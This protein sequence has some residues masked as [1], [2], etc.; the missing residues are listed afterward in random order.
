MDEPARRLIP[1]RS[2]SQRLCRLW[3][4]L[5]PALSLTLAS[6][7]ALEFSTARGDEHFD[8]FNTETPSWK[9]VIQSQADAKLR[10]HRRNLFT[11][12]E[13]AASENLE[14]D[15]LRPGSM[16]R[17]EHELPE[18]AAIDDLALDIGYRSN[19]PGALL[20]L[21][22]VFPGQKDPRT[23]KTLTAL[24]FGNTYTATGEWQNLRVNASKLAVRQR[25]ARL[26]SE[27]R[28]S[29]ISERN[30]FI[31]R[32]IL[33][34][35]LKPGTTELFIDDLKWTGYATPATHA[36]SIRQVSGV[37]S[38]D[39]APQRFEMRLDRLLID[40][41]PIMPRFTLHHGES[42][43]HLKDLGINLVWIDDYA[44]QE[45]LREIRGNEMW[46]MATPPQGRISDGPAADSIELSLNTFDRTS[47][48]ILF[49]YMGTR[50]PGTPRARE[51][52]T[53]QVR[54]VRGADRDFGRP[55]I[56]DIGGY[57][58][59]YSRLLDGVGLSRHPLQTEFSLHRYRQFLTQK[60]RQ[61]RPGTFVTTWIQTEFDP[62]LSAGL[63]TPPL[64][65]PEQIRLQTYAAIAAG[66]QGI[67]FW[68][69]TSLE[70]D[71]AGARERELAIAI[72]N[73]ELALLEPWLATRTITDF[74]R[75]PISGTGV[76]GTDRNRP[77]EIALPSLF[78]RGDQSAS[79]T[80]NATPEEPRDQIELAM[81]HGPN[82]LLLLPVWYQ[83]DAQFV[84]GR[85]ASRAVTLTIPG[86]PDTATV[87]R[88]STT[89]VRTVERT[90]GV[91]GARIHIEDFDQVAALVVSTDPNWGRILRERINPRKTRNAALWV[92]LA[93]LKQTRVRQTNDELHELGVASSRAPQLLNTA[94]GLV[95]AARNALSHLQH[96]ERS[97]DGRVVA[98]SFS[99]AGGDAHTVRS[100][101]DTAL[102]SLRM[103]QREHWENAVRQNSS[104]LTSPGTL[105]FN[106]LP[107][108]WRFVRRLGASSPGTSENLL[109]GG[110]FEN[111]DTQ[112]MIEGG[113]KNWQEPI[114][115]VRA[116]AELVPSR[117]GSGLALR[118]LAV[119]EPNS[120][121]EIEVAGA[122]VAIRTPRIS[123]PG[124]SIA[125]IRGRIRL[126]VAPE[127]TL[128]GVTVTES[129][130]G[131]RLSW[132][133]ATNGWQSF[134]L[135]REVP[136]ASE[137]TLTLTLHGYGD[138][139]FDDLQ[140]VSTSRSPRSDAQASDNPDSSTP[141]P[142]AIRRTLERTREFLNGL[143]GRAG[144][145][146]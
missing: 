23:G 119:P 45:R 89:D 85:M 37:E 48:G 102:Q 111:T 9:V 125:H 115:G 39:P 135:I 81:I 106:S 86:V 7:P 93:E 123:I 38:R 43:A 78:N 30:I 140:V 112:R 17:L 35:Q 14:L 54:L 130:T 40:G 138:V 114:D 129:L 132:T 97:G 144:L 137:L 50:I 101:C 105:S 42:L 145:G 128:D 4:T 103:L 121:P 126:P 3:S 124:D 77:R 98:A 63:Q 22:L 49:W 24:L 5:L 36:E 82:G 16:I 108:H 116:A 41:R 46:A 75:V 12:L 62:D 11:R 34:L 44:D 58:R 31:D 90:A 110:D 71:F 69:R 104:P 1:G 15:A 20:A 19:N 146:K 8:G 65:E 29:E 133:N 26:R 141:E 33:L 100:W 47:D 87:W 127:G 131:G 10:V 91:G 118:L 27:L 25:I 55:V 107:D 60:Y 56:A 120:D 84:P 21:R 2:L 122:P 92:E 109:S 113:W 95:E 117:S 143:P 136:A 6:L 96:A 18:S 66:Y 72:T 139:F 73:E 32:A 76:P 142:G 79:A 70:D 13:G 61:M 53:T 134:E 68:K 28:S 64:I 57:E 99:Q 52:L 51:R 74:Q 59:P 94:Q 88:V 67:G 80:V 83:R